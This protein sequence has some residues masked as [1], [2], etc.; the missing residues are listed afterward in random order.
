MSLGVCAHAHECV[1]WRRGDS[2]GSWELCDLSLSPRHW[3]DPGVFMLRLEGKGVAS[4]VTKTKPAGS[5]SGAIAWGRSQYRA[6]R[7]IS[8]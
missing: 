6:W 2:L 3:P 1:R 8:T 7:S 5:G 4:T